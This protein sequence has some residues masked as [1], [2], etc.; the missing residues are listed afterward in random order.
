VVDVGVGVNVTVGVVVVDVVVVIVV[1][2]LVVYGVVVVVGVVV[3]VDVVVNVV[4][5]VVE[6]GSCTHWPSSF[7]MRPSGQAHC[8]KHS[9][10][11]KFLHVFTPQT[12]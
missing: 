12:E 8:S 1:E 9:L 5:V 10:L 2:V 3:L 7:S 11:V 6:Q 4:V